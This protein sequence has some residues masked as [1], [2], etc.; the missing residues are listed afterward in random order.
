M[1]HQLS[2]WHFL[3]APD[4]QLCPLQHVKVHLDATCPSCLS[5]ELF[6][7]TVPPHGATTSITLRQWLPVVLKAAGVDAT[8]GLS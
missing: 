3:L 5:E 6:V 4:E 7:T 1:G 2:P 8:L